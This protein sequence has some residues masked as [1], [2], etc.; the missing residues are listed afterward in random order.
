MPRF[1]FGDDARVFKGE[2]L[3]LTFGGPPVDLGFALGFG[4]VRRA[5]A[6]EISSN[7]SAGELDGEIL[8]PVITDPVDERLGTLG[9]VPVFQTKLE[10]G[11]TTRALLAPGKDFVASYGGVVDD[12]SSGHVSFLFLG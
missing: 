11:L 3:L 7:P 8:V 12:I 9:H 4:A 6:T 2:K 10:E 1:T 5:K